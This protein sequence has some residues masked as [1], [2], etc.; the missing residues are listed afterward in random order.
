[1][2]RRY[3]V[4]DEELKERYGSLIN[5]LKRIS[6]KRKITQ[7]R[8][9]IRTVTQAH[10]ERKGNKITLVRN[11]ES[12]GFKDP[13]IE[14]VLSKLYIPKAGNPDK[15]RDDVFKLLNVLS[16]D[17]WKDLEKEIEKCATELLAITPTLR[18]RVLKEVYGEESK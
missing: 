18:V 14:T 5:K 16:A 2:P 9:G 11:P 4:S 15:H 7:E 3:P 17:V 10:V 8:L 1:V 6:A 12:V 13:L